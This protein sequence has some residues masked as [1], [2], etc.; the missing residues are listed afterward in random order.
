MDTVDGAT[1]DRAN[2]AA[3]RATQHPRMD[4]VNSERRKA[5]G[6]G[7][8]LTLPV[9]DGNPMPD[10]TTPDSAA[11]GATKGVLAHKDSIPTAAPTRRSSASQETIKE[12][13]VRRCRRVRRDLEGSDSSMIPNRPRLPEARKTTNDSHRRQCRLRR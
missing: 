8:D 5:I 3:M 6:A 7:T 11:M 2:N 10:K 4:I 1:G 9:V 12:R 13:R